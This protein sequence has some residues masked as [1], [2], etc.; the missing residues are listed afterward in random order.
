[1]SDKDVAL[2][3]FPCARTTP[4]H[5]PGGVREIGVGALA[6][7]LGVSDAYR[8][9]HWCSRCQGLWYGLRLEV[10]CPACG[11]RNG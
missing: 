1:M 7:Q 3:N 5:T 10:Q 9:G 6:R 4:A 2:V 11:N 8:G